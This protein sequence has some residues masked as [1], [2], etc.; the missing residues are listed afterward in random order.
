MFTALCIY[1]IIILVVFCLG[2]F[3]FGNE[4]WEPGIIDLKIDTWLVIL[5]VSILWPTIIYMF[6]FE[7][8]ETIDGIKEKYNEIIEKENK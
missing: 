2:L 3:A 6:V 8:R 7:W 1:S 5:V 4:M